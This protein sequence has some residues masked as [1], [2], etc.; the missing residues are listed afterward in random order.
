MEKGKKKKQM[1]VFSITSFW[2][3]NTLL[4]EVLCL[5]ARNAIYPNENKL[6]IC[7]GENVP[8]RQG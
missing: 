7:V 6:S 5:C 8:T 4:A 1:G 2:S 3:V